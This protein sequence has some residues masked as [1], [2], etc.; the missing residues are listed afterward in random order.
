MSRFKQIAIA[1]NGHFDV[2]IIGGG[3]TGAGIFFRCCQNGLKTLLIDA[4]DFASGT[5]SR[6][7]KMIHG[8]LRYLQNL[9]VKLVKEALHEREQL[10]QMFPHLVKPLP[11]LMPI[12]DSKFSLLKMK[13]GLTGYDQLA[14]SSMLPKH[15]MLGKKEVMVQYPMLKKEGLEGAFYYFDALTN[16]ARLTNEVIMNGC[17]LGGIALNYVS[18]KSFQSEKEKI[19]SITAKD[20]IS[21]EE[22]QLK[23][24]H[25]IA[26]AGVWTDEILNQLSTRKEKMM[27]P[28]KGIHLVVDGA[29]FPKKDVL[30]VPCTDKRFLWICPWVDGLV[31]IGATD[32]PYHGELREPGATSDDVQYILQNVN[33]NLE[34]IQLSEADILS[35]YSG[36]RPLIDEKGATNSVKVSRDY[37]IWWEKENLLMI[38]GGKFT[39]F[40]SMADHLLQELSSKVKLK[41]AENTEITKPDNKQTLSSKWGASAG[42]MSAILAENEKNHQFIIEGLEYQFADVIFYIRHQHALKLSDILTRRMAISYRLKKVNQDWLNQI[43]TVMQL[44]LNWSENQKEQAMLEYMQHWEILQTWNKSLP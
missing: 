16:D 18:A 9:Q 12:Y 42:K 23:A 1:K 35:V 10:L 19:T 41:T 37:K 39:S 27:L 13:I 17:N 24:D 5:S 29:R 25:F 11:F 43:A 31:I 4:D 34:G 30:I 7:A 21:G 32:T 8:G 40:L 14:N 33:R 26:A 28:G 2:V 6:S 3:I 22:F 36:L 20:E 44:E 38:A 15:K